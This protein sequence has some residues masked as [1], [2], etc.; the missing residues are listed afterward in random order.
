MKIN[1]QLF[2]K[3]M[4]MIILLGFFIL[5]FKFIK[6]RLI[7][8][9]FRNELEVEFNDVQYVESF[10]LKR[11]LKVDRTVIETLNNEF[12]NLDKEAR[13][14]YMRDI[15]SKKINSI[16]SDYKR[17][18]RGYIETLPLS[19]EFIIIAK[20]GDK[21]YQYGV[22]GDFYDS[23]NKHHYK[24]VDDFIDYDG[25][26]YEYVND[27]ERQKAYDEP[28]YLLDSWGYN[29]NS[30]DNSS[31]GYIEEVPD[32][33][34]GACWALAEKVVKAQ[35][36]SPSSAKFPFSYANKDVSITKSGDI[37]TVKAWVDAENSFGALIRND[38][39]VTMTKSGSKF[40][41]ESCIIY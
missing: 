16:F 17:D 39:T 21:K 35:L 8:S 24:Y 20:A 18:W 7:I 30:S 15:L 3:I 41:S 32:D 36:K 9:K 5:G 10:R 13:H 40:T 27:E 19:D 2:K 12:N 11:F 28:F 4:I 38:F 26:R 14:I 33:E 31:Y 22:A 25:E 34:L 29:E 1:K 37:Y 23:F 6:G